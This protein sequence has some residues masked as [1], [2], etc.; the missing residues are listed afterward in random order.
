MN[1]ALLVAAREF[2]ANTRTKGFII[3]LIV[4][5]AVIAGIVIVPTLFGSDS[6][7]IGLV[8]DQSRPL[9]PVLVELAEE[10]GAD[11]ET[12]TVSSE[13]A[14]RAAVD[15]GD[16][17]AAVVEARTVLTAGELD[18]Q[19]EALLQQA[20]RAVATEQQ[21]AAAGLEPQ[22]IQDALQVAPLEL[23]SVT[24]DTR[25]EGP[26]QALAFL[27]VLV[28]FFL[29]LGST[30]LVATGVVE[31]KGSRIVEILLVAVH[32]WRLLAG[33]IVAFTVLGIIQLAVFAAAGIIAAAVVGRLPELP[34]GTPGVF[35]AAFAGFLLGFLF[36]AA[37]AAAMA[38]L[39][40]RQEE[41]GQ[42][43]TPMTLTIIASYM[44]G[45]WALNNP[46][47]LVGYVLSMTPP[48]AAMVMP[49]RVATTEVPLWEIAVASG[50]MLAAAVAVLIVG[51]RIYERAV[52]RT[53][54][55]MKLI[56][57]WRSSR[58]ATGVTQ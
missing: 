42:V 36:Y 15:D 11:V 56:E 29:I 22:Q 57:A 52:L 58:V 53:G 10:S 31:E 48:F 16:L 3:G 19:V 8:G 39:V 2:R 18:A 27:T 23:R 21:L 35:G 5:A 12:S 4:S 30:M 55:R 25:Y 50:G 20:H 41:V 17:D 32:P 47:A 49:V 54:A 9:E 44:V 45:I 28:L 24:G 14:A 46:D 33:K 51:G 34:P 37:V 43:T 1:D 13:D 6:Y 38:S 7:H 26:R 40:S